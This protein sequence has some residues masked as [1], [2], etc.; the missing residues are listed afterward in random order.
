M[1]FLF[2]TYCNTIPVYF[3]HPQY[4]TIYLIAITTNLCTYLYSYTVVSSYVRLHF[5]GLD[6][7]YILLPLIYFEYYLNVELYALIY[8]CLLLFKYI[9]TIILFDM[10]YFW[11]IIFNDYYWLYCTLFFWCM[12]LSILDLILFAH[13][14]Y[15]FWT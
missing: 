12:F 1:L 2:L 10:I 15:R 9:D 6:H 13:N 14:Q 7:L 3:W 8:S 11:M 5:I 4:L